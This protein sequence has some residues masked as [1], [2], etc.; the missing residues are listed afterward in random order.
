MIMRTS[1]EALHNTLAQ[2]EEAIG[3][4]EIL[5]EQQEQRGPISSASLEKLLTER[6][7]VTKAII[8]IDKGNDIWRCRL[9]RLRWRTVDDCEAMNDAQASRFEPG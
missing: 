2:I 5:R 8:Q 9:E 7:T 3:T 1:T 6:E 4:L